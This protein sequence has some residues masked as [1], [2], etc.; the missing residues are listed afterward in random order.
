MQK[1]SFTLLFSLSLVISSSAIH[2]A[3]AADKGYC[4]SY[5]RALINLPHKNTDKNALTVCK[6]DQPHWSSDKAKHLEW[7]LSVSQVEADKKLYSHNKLVNLCNDTYKLVMIDRLRCATP[8]LSSDDAIEMSAAPQTLK[9]A[10]FGSNK[11]STY[12]P[13][14]TLY[15]TVQLAI[16]D[17]RIHQCDIHSLAV[18]LDNNAQSKEWILSIDANCLDHKKQGHTWLV[19][20][21]GDSYHVLFEA[22]DSTL[23]LRY[24]QTDN[25]KNITVASPLHPDEETNKRCG[26][27]I[28]DWHYAGGRY[29]PVTGKADPHGS[30]LPEY[31]L[32]DYLQ[33]VNIDSLPPGEWEKNI[34]REDEKRMELYA[35]YKKTLNDYVPEWLGKIEK[36]VPANPRL[37]SSASQFYKKADGGFKPTENKED[38]DKGF[39]QNVR[40]FLGIE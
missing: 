7:C 28:A 38:T 21:L 40:S 35:P 15:P 20:Q 8:P 23:T 25:F 19:Q 17:G 13:Y 37:K 22:E 39:M 32:P 2:S 24:S 4:Q 1:K 10:L 3:Q 33:G 31:N 12:S 14:A 26:S 11:Q 36:L 5:S 34:K 27:I 16:K 18:D 9:D 6:A 30:C 29:L